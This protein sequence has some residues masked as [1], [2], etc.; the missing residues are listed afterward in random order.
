MDNRYYYR[1][2]FVRPLIAFRCSEYASPVSK[3]RCE[4]SFSGIALAD[5]VRSD[6]PERAALAQQ[7]K[8]AAEKM[9]DQIGVAVRPLVQSLQPGQIV[10]SRRGRDGVL[11]GEW[12][13][14]DYG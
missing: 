7:C 14:S 13:I 2:P 11:A 1:R 4:P 3:D 5:C 8:G 9:C 10:R 12:R 6:K